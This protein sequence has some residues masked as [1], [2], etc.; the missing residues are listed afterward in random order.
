M[1]RGMD[2]TPADGETGYD[3]TDFFEVIYFTLIALFSNKSFLMYLTK[4][5]FSIDY[6]CT[7]LLSL[8][9]ATTMTH[10]HNVSFSHIK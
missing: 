3:E 10:A 1:S 9:L 5:Y 4:Y 8:F 6:Q 2:T 7:L